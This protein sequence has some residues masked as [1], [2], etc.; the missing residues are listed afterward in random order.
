MCFGVL[1]LTKVIL[2]VPYT[3]RDRQLVPG[4]VDLLSIM[5]ITLGSTA[6]L[7]EWC[8]SQIYTNTLYSVPRDY[9]ATKGMLVFKLC[10]S[11]GIWLVKL[12]GNG[13]S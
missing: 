2:A 11:L 5:M 9:S 10:L 4:L 1:I 7:K 3:S 12:T 8:E 13:N 6:T